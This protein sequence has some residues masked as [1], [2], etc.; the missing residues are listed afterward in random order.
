MTAWYRALSIRNDKR[1]FGGALVTKIGAYELHERNKTKNLASRWWQHSR[2]CNKVEG[3]FSVVCEGGKHQA[4]MATYL[5]DYSLGVVPLMQK[6]LSRGRLRV[7]GERTVAARTE[8]D[9][10]NTKY[11]ELVANLPMNPISLTERMHFSVA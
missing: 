6:W 5:R 9:F 8:L 3:L 10:S 2:S 4:F 7:L 11:R 1:L